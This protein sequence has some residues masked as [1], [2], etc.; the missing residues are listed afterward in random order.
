VG[1]EYDGPRHAALAITL[2]GCE[3]SGLLSGTCQSE[4][5]A[6]GEVRSA[7][8]QAQLGTIKTGLVPAT[9]WELSPL[10]G[11]TVAGMSCGG[12][13]L[14]LT[15]AVIG[16]VTALD[17][18]SPSFTLKFKGSGTKQTPE[19]FEGGPQRILTMHLGGGEERAGLTATAVPAGEENLEIKAIV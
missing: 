1:G 17:K 19:R 14:S 5:A 4:G 11:T 9:G 2:T 3:A 16:Q 6:S 18:M 10:S 12:T 8:L 13:P 15:G 7:A